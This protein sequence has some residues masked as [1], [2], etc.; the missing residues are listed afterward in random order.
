[1]Q[2]LSVFRLKIHKY[3]KGNLKDKLVELIHFY[4][5]SVRPLVVKV[6]DVEKWCALYQMVLW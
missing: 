6:R 4:G 5:F 1:M 2:I 3:L